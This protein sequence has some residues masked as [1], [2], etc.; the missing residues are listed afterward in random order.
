MEQNRKP[1][2]PFG[3]R[4]TNFC[5]RTGMTLITVAK[6]SDVKV[7]TLRDCKIGRSVGREVVPKVEA[8]MDSYR[9]DH[10]EL[11]KEEA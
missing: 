1:Q 8:Y 4:V 2:T 11:F 9:K 5:A 10:P 6:N 3:I 7:G